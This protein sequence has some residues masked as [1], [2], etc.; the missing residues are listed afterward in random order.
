MGF[1]QNDYVRFSLYREFFRFPWN[2]RAIWL[3]IF[4]VG[5]EY[6]FLSRTG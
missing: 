5:K 2:R 6:F 4:N 3:C 1:F